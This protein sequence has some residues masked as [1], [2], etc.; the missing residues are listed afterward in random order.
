MSPALHVAMG[1]TSPMGQSSTDPRASFCRSDLRAFSLRPTRQSGRLTL[2]N[3][4]GTAAIPGILCERK[5]RA[6]G[7][8]SVW[9]PLKQMIRLGGAS[10]RWCFRRL[11]TPGHFPAVTGPV[12]PVIAAQARCAFGHRCTPCGASSD[13][14]GGRGRRGPSIRRRAGSWNFQETAEID[15]AVVFPR[16]SRV[17]VRSWAVCCRH[18]VRAPPRVKSPSS[19]LKVNLLSF[20]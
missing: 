1:V 3:G 18:N 19:G 15:P 7:S 13:G 4:L 8:K 11:K 9:R 2:E 14:G 20:P 6:P 16:D 17:T 12:S 10:G 5:E